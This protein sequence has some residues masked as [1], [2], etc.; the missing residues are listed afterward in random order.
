MRPQRLFHRIHI[1]ISILL[2]LWHIITR[3]PAVDICIHPGS[4]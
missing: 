4:V 2:R 1:R 3:K